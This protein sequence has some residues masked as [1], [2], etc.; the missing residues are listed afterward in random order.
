MRDIYS[1]GQRQVGRPDFGLGV[2]LGVWDP[3]GR[4]RGSPPCDSRS[5]KLNG[6]VAVKMPEFDE[7]NLSTSGNLGTFFGGDRA[8][9]SFF[10]ATVKRAA[11]RRLGRCHTNGS[12][13]EEGETR[14]GV[15]E[16]GMVDS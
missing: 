10:P 15:I 6:T 5:N 13:R 9:L 2:G 11:I 8:P 14:A 3:G 4:G 1:A 12:W 16:G 7:I